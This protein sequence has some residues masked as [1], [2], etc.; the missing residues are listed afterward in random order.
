MADHLP[1]RD[2]DPLDWDA[3]DHPHYAAPTHGSPL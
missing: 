2:P 1:D 3:D